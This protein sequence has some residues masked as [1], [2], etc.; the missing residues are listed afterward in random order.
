MMKLW[1][2]ATKKGSKPTSRSL[3]IHRRVDQSN[4][5]NSVVSVDP[6]FDHS[7]PSTA[8]THYIAAYKESSANTPTGE[9]QDD[10]FRDT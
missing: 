3:H 4:F 6:D 10:I 1:S 5:V 8:E 2:L 7:T 9:A